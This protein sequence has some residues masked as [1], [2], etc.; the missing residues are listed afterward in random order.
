MAHRGNRRN[1]NGA[2]TTV[3]EEVGPSHKFRR[4]TG[5]EDDGT[6]CVVKSVNS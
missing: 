3:D 4:V 5:E 2:V 1:L 6:L